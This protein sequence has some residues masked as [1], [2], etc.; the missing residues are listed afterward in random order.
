MAGES[1]PADEL[2][3]MLVD[4]FAKLSMDRL[5]SATISERKRRP[6]AGKGV[7]APKYNM[8]NDPNLHLDDDDIIKF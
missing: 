7:P 1:A 8:G 5:G 2:D 6:P 3:K 4:G